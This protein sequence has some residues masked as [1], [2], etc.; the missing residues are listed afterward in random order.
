M[1]NQI[2]GTTM[3]VEAELQKKEKVVQL[4]PME[5][6]EMEDREYTSAINLEIILEKMDT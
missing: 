2:V 4:G 6:Q 5:N 3:E 1:V